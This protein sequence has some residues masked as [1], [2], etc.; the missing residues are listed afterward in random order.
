MRER[1]R[2]KKRKGRAYRLDENVTNGCARKSL[3]KIKRRLKCYANALTIYEL[4]KD[5]GIKA[6]RCENETAAGPHSVFWTSGQR[7]RKELA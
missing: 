7:R 4:E 3:K 6:T 5:R 2:K 1:K